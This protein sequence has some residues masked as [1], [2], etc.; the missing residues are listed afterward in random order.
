[1]APVQA[2]PSDD[3]ERE[4]SEEKDSEKDSAS[5][6]DEPSPTPPTSIT[7]HT[8]GT[9]PVSSP[10]QSAPQQITTASTRRKSED[11]ATRRKSD[12]VQPTAAPKDVPGHKAILAQRAQVT[13]A[14]EEVL[15]AIRAEAQTLNRKKVST[16]NA[17][18][19][20]VEKKAALLEALKKAE[21]DQLQCVMNEQYLQADTFNARIEEIKKELQAGERELDQFEKDIADLDQKLFDLCS[22]QT[23]R[24]DVYSSQLQD[25]AQSN[26]RGLAAFSGDAT[27]RY[28][29]AEERI[30]EDMEK[31]KRAELGARVDL[32]NLQQRE[33]KL[34]DKIAEQT[35]EIRADLDARTREHKEVT[36]E[37]ADLEAKLE[38]KRRLQNSLEVQIADLEHKVGQVR[39]DFAE[40]LN[41]VE[42]QISQDTIRLNDCKAVIAGLDGDRAANNVAKE[43]A[44][45][46]IALRR[47]II[48]DAYAEAASI[49]TAV[50]TAQ[51][52]LVQ[53]KAQTQEHSMVK[54]TATHRT[55][56]EA[57]KEI[58]QIDE[59]IHHSHSEIEQ[60][61]KKAD[62]LAAQAQE[63][64]KTIP[65]LEAAK[66]V[67]VAN[68]A[69]K[70]AQ[71]KADQ[72]RK[73]TE[74]KEK[75][76][77]DAKTIRESV[78]V[79]ESSVRLRSEELRQ[80]SEDVA[81]QRKR[82]VKEYH[83]ALLR[84]QALT[85]N[86]LTEPEMLDGQHEASRALLR[87][88]QTVLNHLPQEDE[89]PDSPVTVPAEQTKETEAPH[90]DGMD[91]D[92]APAVGPENATQAP[93]QDTQEDEPPVPPQQPTRDPEEVRNEIADLEAQIQ[94]HSEREEYDQCDALEERVKALKALLES[95]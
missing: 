22:K 26:E 24:Q 67:A 54:Y 73:L 48:D 8:N 46:E 77:A 80:K 32:E 42:S 59:G 51:A 76:D 81:T 94:N 53:R 2:P 27:Q 28:E 95:S 60:L 57:E 83:A 69:F 23:R 3:E 88:I 17:K 41:R 49:R 29:S 35:K 18:S 1:V 34:N 50:S 93:V 75:L 16:I 5:E 74:E 68:R 64:V 89:T 79:L 84:Y 33:Q 91:T 6:P 14:H 37:I 45:Q 86:L 39:G 55:L 85:E 43:A 52:D 11:P 12:A 71:A 56:L 19:T 92:L 38:M 58:A 44:E 9:T 10:E 20:S 4:E 72:I 66:K 87:W 36:D 47:T 15:K 82:W 13:A 40:N 70:D 61:N 78:A 21:A 30:R 65:E 62:S 7:H 63:A 31:A 90:D 25:L